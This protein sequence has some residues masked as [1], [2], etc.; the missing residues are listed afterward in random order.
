MVEAV[1]TR[2]PP[3]R[4]SGLRRIVP[5]N[6]DIFTSNGIPNRLS[7]LRRFPTNNNFLGNAGGLGNNGFLGS[8]AYLNNA[9]LERAR[10][11]GSRCPDRLTPF[12]RHFL[13]LQIDILLDG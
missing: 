8:L 4:K 13:A 2:D 1:A 6:L 9:L 3:L 11:R 7:P 12:H 5:G 10:P